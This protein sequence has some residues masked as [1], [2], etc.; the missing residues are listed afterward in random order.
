ME[1]K[2]EI[3]TEIQE[4]VKQLKKDREAGNCGQYLNNL[5]ALDF[6]VSIQQRL[7]EIN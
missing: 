1:L 2:S 6:L 3:G 7:N 5:K 4:I